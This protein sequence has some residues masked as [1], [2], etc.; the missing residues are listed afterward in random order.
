[1]WVGEATYPTPRHFVNESIAQGVSRRIGALPRGAVPGETQ[2]AL[3]H[4]KAFSRV[5]ENGI[6]TFTAGV[7]MVFLLKEVQYVVTG[8]ET[9]EELEKLAARGIEPVEVR[10]ANEQANFDFK[11]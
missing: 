2:I 8:Q 4:R 5:G 1:M 7:F 11:G 9:P 10:R 6:V 3:A